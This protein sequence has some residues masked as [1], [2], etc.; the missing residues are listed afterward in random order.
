MANCLLR[1]YQDKLFR[2]E[3]GGRAWGDYL[4]KEI[5]LLG[6]GELTTDTAANELNWEVLCQAIDQWNEQN[7]H[8]ELGYPKTRS[9]MDGWT[10]LFDRSITKGGGSV[11]M[12]FGEIPQITP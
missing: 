2:G 5:G 6:Y 3:Q 9:Y 12:P 1:I 10:T 4:E 8:K 7:P 11:Y